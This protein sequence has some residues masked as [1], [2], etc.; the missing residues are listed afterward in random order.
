MEKIDARKL[1][2]SA[3]MQT[4]RMAVRIRQELNLTYKEIARVLG[5]RTGTVLAWFHSHEVRGEAAFQSKKRGRSYGSG[6]TLTLAQEW[7]LR[8]VVTSES[9][10]TR[11]LDFALW[12]RRAVM[13]L[14]DKLF[15]IQMSIRTVGEYLRR[16]GY[17]PQRPSLQAQERNPVDVQKWIEEVYPAIERYANDQGAI[18]YWGDETAVQQDSRWIRGYAPVGQTPVLSAPSKRYGVS[19]VS[20]LSSE[21]DVRYEFLDGAINTQR[22]IDFLHKFIDQSQ[23]KVVL[24]LDNLRVHHAVKVNEWLQQH[25]DRIHVFFL[26]PYTPQN[27]PDEYLNRDFKTHIRSADRAVSKDSLIEKASDFMNLL[28]ETPERVRSYFKNSRVRFAR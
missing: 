3:L 12:S 9:P 27:N 11:G 5:V 19:M 22:A 14:I 7:A 26:P 4:R 6:R 24:I 8:T 17:T 1:S 25:Q 18:I 28:K 20:A 23:T 16:W 10:K 21:G 2:S 15:G 13:Q